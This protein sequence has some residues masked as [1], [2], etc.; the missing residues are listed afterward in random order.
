VDNRRASQTDL[1]S[2]M[3]TFSAWEFGASHFMDAEL[4]LIRGRS[5]AESRGF[6]TGTVDDS[7]DC[8]DKHQN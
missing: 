7:G 3:E 8:T 2:D 6:D 4:T 5:A 1:I